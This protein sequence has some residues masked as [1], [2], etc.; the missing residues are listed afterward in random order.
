MACTGPVC[1]RCSTSACKGRSARGPQAAPPAL[2]V[3]ARS[4]H[5]GGRARHALHRA[6]PG[7][8]VTGTGFTAGLAVGARGDPAALA[9]RTTGSG[10]RSFGRVVAVLAEVPSA[11]EQMLDAVARAAAGQVRPG[12]SLCVRLHKR[13]AH[14]YLD[15]TPA[16]ERAAGTAAWQALHR[17]DGAGPRVD[18]VHPDVTIHV[19]VPGPRTLIG[20]ARTTGPHLESGRQGAGWA[21]AHTASPCRPDP[22][23]GP[24]RR[25]AAYADFRGR[26]SA[27]G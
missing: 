25:A 16:L 2:I 13:G 1:A 14:G 5:D 6:L 19:E 26:E 9:A 3:T 21:H 7:A 10:S 23:R 18:L 17:R 11:R 15:L 27:P 12:E 4:L 20:V 22:G 8:R 24:G